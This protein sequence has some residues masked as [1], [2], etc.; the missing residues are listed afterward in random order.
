MN[1]ILL[2]PPGAGKGTQA[3]R[4][5]ESR[6]LVQISTGEMLRAAAEAGTLVGLKAKPIMDSGQLVPD[7]MIVDIL[8]ERMLQPDCHNGIIL[9]G[10]PRTVAQAEVLDSMLTAAGKK[11]D[12]VIRMVVE[13]DAL[14]KRIAGRF[15]CAKC[16]ASYHDKFNP[17]RVAGLCDI[18]GAHDFVRR[19]DDKP[20]T[21]H[22]RL[23]AY[24]AQ[25]KPIIPYYERAGVLRRVDGM[26]DIETVSREIEEVLDAL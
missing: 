22:K 8:H 12:V 23:E 15:S 24:N 2:G 9:D 19:E 7:G 17:T 4:L 26:A 5:A 25:T 20:E 3:K 10:F 6:G 11:L 18:C 21:I 14:V 16:G 13:E 1:L